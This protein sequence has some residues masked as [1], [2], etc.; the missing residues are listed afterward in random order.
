MPV[1]TAAGNFTTAVRSGAELRLLL[2]ESQGAPPILGTLPKH[3][4]AS[5]HVSFL[6]GPE[7]GWT[8]QERNEA[9]SLGWKPCSLGDTILRAETA[10]I[11]A[12]SIVQAFWTAAR[13]EHTATSL[14]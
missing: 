11:A 3:P 4:L 9:L 2:D 8:E 10:T 1:I 7:G 14:E 6:L 13:A 5:D 12:L